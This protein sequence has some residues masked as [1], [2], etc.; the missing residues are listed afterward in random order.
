[1]FNGFALFIGDHD[2]PAVA[3]FTDG[4]DLVDIFY[5]EMYGAGADGFRKTVVGIVLMVREYGDPST[6]ERGRNGLST[7]VHKTPLVKLVVTK[8]DIASV[9]GV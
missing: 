5:A 9:D 1:M 7:D 8:L 2:F 4:A 3:C 6:D